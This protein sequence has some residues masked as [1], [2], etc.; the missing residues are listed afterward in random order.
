MTLIEQSYAHCR[1]VARTQA[2]NFYYSFL[3]LNKPRRNAMC[4]MYAFNRRSDDLSD[5]GASA[6]VE[7]LESWRGDL[8]RA[9][10]GDYGSDPCW[11]AFHDAVQRYS[12]PTEYFHRMIDG[13]SSDLTPRDM[14]TF[15]ELYRYCYQV[16]SVVGMT[17]VHIFGFHDRRALEL[18]E[19]CGVAFQLTNILRD[20]KEDADRGRNYLPREDRDRFPEFRDLMAFEA[21]RAVAYYRESAPLV[22]MI[23]KGSRRSLWALIEIYRRLLERIVA[24]N[25]DVLSHRIR[26]STPEKL[27]I[28]AKAL[29]RPMS[30]PRP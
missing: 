2:K 25:Y 11:P 12:I 22:A 24:S 5:D 27:S 10:R 7:T 3:L 20:V 6:T 4:A 16:A 14:Q 8:D 21:N 26:L 9:L 23:D 15:D 28:V 29:L 30:E 18:A 1:R 19:K 13:V 17:T